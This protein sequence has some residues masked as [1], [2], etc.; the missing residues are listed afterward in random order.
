MEVV[1]EAV[2]AVVALVTTLVRMVMENKNKIL[3]EK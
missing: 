1:V 2:G 3:K